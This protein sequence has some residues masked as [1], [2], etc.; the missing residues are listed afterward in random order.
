MKPL[1]LE[2]YKLLYFLT[3]SKVFSYYSAVV[4]VTVLNVIV[5]MGLSLLLDGVLPT[6]A[7]LVIFKF[8]FYI[9]TGVGLFLINLKVA[10][11]SFMELA[12]HVQVRYLKLLVY[13]IV[14]VI[15]LGYKMLLKIA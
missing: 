3:G 14:A 2:A 15:I 5:L 4:I 6:K 9:A 8:P 7:I 11:M 13:V 1:T 10:P 12:N